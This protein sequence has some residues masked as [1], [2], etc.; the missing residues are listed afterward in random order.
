MRYFDYGTVA[1]EAAIP[2]DKLEQLRQLTR[3]EFPRDGMMCELHLLRACM[4]IRDGVATLEEA[5][6]PELA[7]GV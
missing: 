6:K 7:G 3:R 1:S 2:R 4:A 5:L